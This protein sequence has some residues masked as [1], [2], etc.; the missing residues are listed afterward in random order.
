MRLINGDCKLEG[1][2]ELQQPT[3][4]PRRLRNDETKKAAPRGAAFFM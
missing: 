3:L 1:L 2:G 4:S